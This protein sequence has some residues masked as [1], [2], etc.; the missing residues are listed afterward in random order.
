M[1]KGNSLDFNYY[2]NQMI[3]EQENKQVAENSNHTFNK[4]PFLSIKDLQSITKHISKNKISDKL[5]RRDIQYYDL[6]ALQDPPEDYDTMRN[7][8][9]PH[10]KLDAKIKEF[11]GDLAFP[12]FNSIF[13]NH[14]EI[15]K[16]QYGQT[17]D[18]SLSIKRGPD[19]K[20]K[21]QR[22]VKEDM[23]LKNNNIEFGTSKQQKDNNAD[24]IQL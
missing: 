16:K 1:K 20:M 13:K 24:D 11:Y 12:N 22:V 17:I 7:E 19:G 2:L 6:Y 14:G 4:K 8:G 3:A 10:T 5:S 15:V 18:V 21:V 9:Y 23:A